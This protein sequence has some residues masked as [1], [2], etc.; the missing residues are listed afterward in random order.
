MGAQNSTRP[1]DTEQAN[2]DT[3]IQKEWEII[4]M[5]ARKLKDPDLTT[6]E[7]T[8]ASR[9]IAYHMSIL[10]KMLIQKGEKPQFTEKTLGELLQD[11]QPQIRRRVRREFK[12]WQKSLSLRRS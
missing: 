12:T 2:I 8:H 6:A 5:L 10:Y 4:N 11:M 7:W 9:V 1:A 3:L